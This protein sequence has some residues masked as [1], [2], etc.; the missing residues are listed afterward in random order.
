MEYQFKRQFIFGVIILALVGGIIFISSKLLKTKATCSDGI[1]NQNEEQVDCGGLCQACKVTRLEDIKVLSHNSFSLKDGSY[2]AY[3]EIKNQNI[4]QGAEA[5]S[6]TFS[7]YDS[8][9]KLIGERTGKSYVLANQTRYI[10]ESNIQLSGQAAFTSF[11]INPDV[12]WRKQEAG[13]FNLSVFSQKY[14]SLTEGIGP[15]FAKAT[16]VV[17]NQTEHDF[18]EVEV[19]AVL[20][21]KNNKIFAVGKTQIDNLRFGEN[22]LFAVLFPEEIPPPSN[23]YITANTNIFNPANTR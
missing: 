21:D 20:V 15:G 17:E 22:R 13:E 18:G 16:G 10:I 2:D 12:S 7:F 6:Y 11:A 19:D 9:K 3:A 4:S 1:L 14:E 8:D 23:V 5:L